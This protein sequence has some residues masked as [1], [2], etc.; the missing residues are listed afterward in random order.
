MTSPSAPRRPGLLVLTLGALS[1]FG[2]LSIDMYLPSLPVIQQ[3]LA[4]SASSV[5]LTLAAYM[6]G[7]CVGQ[8]IY[9]PLADRFGRRRPLT[10]GVVLYVLASAA[11]AYA[12]SI[13]AL[14]ALRF[15][16]AIGGAAGP[17]IARAVVRDYYNGREAA[18]ILSLLMLVMGAAPILAPT[19]GGWVLAISGWRAIFGVLAGVGIACLLFAVN[20]L[21][22]EAER[23]GSPPAP[24]A[25]GRSL[26]ALVSDRRFVAFTLTGGF[27]QAGMFAYISG[28]PFVLMGLHH[29]SPRTFSWVFGV[30][31]AGLVAASQVNRRLLSS[32]SPT[33]IAITATLCCGLMGAVLVGLALTGAGGVHAILPTLFLFLTASGFVAPNVT[34]LAMEDHGERAGVASSLLGSAQFAVAAGASSLVGLLNDGTMLPMAATMALCALMA[35]VLG[36]TAPKRDLQGEARLA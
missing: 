32:F 19:L 2:P 20:T 3:E 34:A 24:G 1:A 15:L 30:N 18:R 36:V 12:P 4:T 29:L 11:C 10:T 28:S 16:Q 6:A 23:S 22:R 8:L 7:L 26:R 17:V 33:R 5:Q 21:P 14:I 27:A 13:H 35:W 25:L 9:G 31:A